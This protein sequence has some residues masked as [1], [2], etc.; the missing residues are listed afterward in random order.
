LVFVGLTLVFSSWNDEERRAVIGPLPAAPDYADSSQWFMVE[1]N[2]EADL[3]YIISTE[4]G[5]HMMGEDTC[6]LADTYDEALRTMMLKEMTAVDSFYSGRLNYFSPYYRQASLNSWVKQEHAYARLPIAIEDVKHSWDYYLKHLNQGRPFIIAGYSQGGIAVLDILKEMPDSIFSR[7]VAAYVIGF[8]VT[9]EDVDSN[10]HIKL[11]QDSTDTGVLIG[12]NSVK[13]PESIIYFTENNVACINPVSWR[14]DEEPTPFVLYGRRR[15]D[16]LSV[17]CD[18]VSHH[19]MV[20]GITKHRP[21]PVIGK[22]GNYHNME[23]KFY[24]PYVRKNMADRVAAFLAK[25]KE[26]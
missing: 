20:D 13:S 6:H 18:T 12:F 17:R 7:L 14:T 3:F 26:E 9:Q 2:G 23:L 4:T 11:A 22:P 5:D 8:K 25:K 1:R 21:M 24:Y 19:L 15:N 16:T 10:K